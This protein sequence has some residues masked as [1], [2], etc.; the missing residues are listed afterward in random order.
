MNKFPSLDNVDKMLSLTQNV[1]KDVKIMKMDHEEKITFLE[2]SINK[3]HDKLRAVVAVSRTTMQNSINGLKKLNE[4]E[5][6]IK[7]LTN[8]NIG[9]SSATME[10]IGKDAAIDQHGIGIGPILGLS[11][12]MHN[13]DQV[14]IIHDVL[15]INEDGSSPY[16]P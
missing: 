14:H 3:V 8:G 2:E 16:Y 5:W 9:S 7:G 13:H 4:K 1:T 11:T 12:R 10:D 15:N 6:T